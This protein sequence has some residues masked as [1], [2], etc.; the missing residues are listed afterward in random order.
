MCVYVRAP[1]HPDHP[2]IRLIGSS[3]RVLACASMLAFAGACTHSVMYALECLIL[4]R[5]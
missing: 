2:S 5:R 4:S 1:M 3:A